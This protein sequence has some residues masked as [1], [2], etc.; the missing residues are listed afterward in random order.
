METFWNTHVGKAKLNH[1]LAEG[2]LCVIKNA[3]P[4]THGTNHLKTQTAAPFAKLDPWKPAKACLHGGALI[5]L[6]KAEG[7]AKT[8]AIGF[9][10]S[11]CCRRCVDRCNGGLSNI[12]S[13][14]DISA[15]CYKR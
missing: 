3:R 13:L 4:A 5:E 15:C 14:N 10:V 1:S 6:M 9:G 7:V 8:A 12:A 11:V 2:G